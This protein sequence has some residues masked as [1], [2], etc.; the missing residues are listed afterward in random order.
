MCVLSFIR[1][2]MKDIIFNGIIPFFCVLLGALLSYR[3]QR[4]S[5][6]K[7]EDES[8]YADCLRIMLSLSTMYTV[9]ITSVRFILIHSLGMPVLIGLC[10]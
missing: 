3:I 1:P 2:Y 6:E 8:R 10:G 4:N 5:E 9:L 7:R